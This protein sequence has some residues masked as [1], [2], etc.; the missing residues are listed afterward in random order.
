MKGKGNKE[1]WRT[2]SSFNTNRE[3]VKTLKKESY[4][5]GK[6]LQRAYHYDEEIWFLT[7]LQ[8]GWIIPSPFTS[9]SRKAYEILLLLAAEKEFGSH[10]P[11]H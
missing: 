11:H 1:G 3:E 6:I 8:V 4:F 5:F 10:C 7:L 9:A 2:F